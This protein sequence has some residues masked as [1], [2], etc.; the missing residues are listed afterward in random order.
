MDRITYVEIAGSKYP[1]SFSL[2]ASKAFA[3]KFG[4]I[5]KMGEVMRGAGDGVSM[6]TLDAITYIMAVL[7]QQGV[8]YMNLFCKDL[9]PEKGARIENEKYVALTEEE[10]QNLGV[11]MH[12]TS[13]FEVGEVVTISDGPMAGSVCTITQINE[14]DSSLSAK[15]FMMGRET[16]VEL[17]FSQVKKL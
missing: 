7:I 12:E 4:S 15:I 13:D 9:P 17:K 11:H 10:V 14:A 16:P 5:D 8:A 2:G 1:L 3:K 6:E